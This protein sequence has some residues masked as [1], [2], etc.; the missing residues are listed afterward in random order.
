M[1]YASSTTHLLAKLLHACLYN[2]IGREI[3]LFY[4]KCFNC[5]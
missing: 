5:E 1:A 4:M 2:Y 3:E